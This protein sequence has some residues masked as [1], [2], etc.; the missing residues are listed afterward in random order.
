MEHHGALG[1]LQAGCIYVIGIP[2]EGKEGTEKLLG[3]LL[4]EAFSNLDEN[5]KPA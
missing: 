3:K 2:R 4:V 5:C 1:P